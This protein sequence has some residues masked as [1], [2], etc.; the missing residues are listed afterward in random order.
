ML[1]GKY[2]ILP[3]Q[4][5]KTVPIQNPC[6]YG[7]AWFVGKL[8]YVDGAKAE[9]S[10]LKNINRRVEAVADKEFEK[11]LG[12]AYANAAADTTAKITLTAY[13]PNE[14]TYKLNSR[15]GGVVV[16][17]EIYYPGWTATLDGKDIPIGRVDYVLRALRVSAGQHT[18]VLK[19]DPQSLHTTEAVAYAALAVMLLA[20][21]MAVV[22][23]LR[24]KKGVSAV[25]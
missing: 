25:K 6:A 14:L 11:E 5:G 7:N 9:M 16:L 12:A 21:V 15:G 13:E 10:L 17:S 22:V 2:F 24:R 23:S 4:D 20:L 1:N 18:L 8:T 19:F 3:L